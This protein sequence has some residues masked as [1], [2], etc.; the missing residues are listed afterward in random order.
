[1]VMVSFAE[2]AV[3]NVYAATNAK[4]SL[5][6]IPPATAVTLYTTKLAPLATIV[7]LVAVGFKNAGATGPTELPAVAR[8]GGTA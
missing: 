2:V 1:M 3:G 8:A 5:T 4:L 6:A 7:T